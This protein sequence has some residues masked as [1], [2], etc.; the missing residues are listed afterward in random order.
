MRD[1]ETLGGVRA[2]VIEDCSKEV[3][4]SGVHETAGVLAHL[5]SDLFIE[6]RDVKAWQ[7]SDGKYF[8]DLSEVTDADLHG[9]LSGER[10]LGHYLLSPEDRCRLLAFDLDLTGTGVWDGEPIA[11]R[12]EFA[13]PDSP[14]RA[15]LT[16]QV[17]IAAETLARTIF[18]EL[19]VPVAIAF[20]GSKGGHV[21]GFTGSEPASLVRGAALD[22][23]DAC[24][25]FRA[26][27]GASFFAHEHDEMNVHVEVFPKQAS[28]EGKKLGNL[29]RLPLGRNRKTGNEGFFVQVGGGRRSTFYP[30]DPV[31]A[32]GGQLPWSDQ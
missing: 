27:Q 10:T 17:L 26:A 11:P 3:A 31:A 7:C 28:L 22:V 20:S 29:M 8:P 25:C 14:H 30:M 16:G 12:A 21:Y 23:I 32:L 24:D 9:H 18:R 1:V 4:R 15:G 2:E 13:N 6:R 5:L 19:D